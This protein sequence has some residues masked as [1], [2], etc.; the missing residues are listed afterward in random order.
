ME[1][2]QEVTI[3]A[4]PDPLLVS[5]QAVFP[6]IVQLADDNLLAIF[7]IGQAFDAAD[8]RAFCSK[9]KDLGR[10]WTAPER[11]HSHEFEPDQISETLKP[12]LLRDGSLLAT[13]Y[14]FVRPDDLAPIVDP[15][16]FE[17]LPLRNMVSKSTD[18]GQSWDV[19]RLVNIGGQPLEMS[20]PCIQLQS[21]RIL[22]AAPPFHLGAE[23]HSGW[24]VYS[25][26][27]GQNW[28]KLSTF[29]ESSSG[30]VAAWECRL[31]ETK[32][33]Q[34]VVLFWAYDNR[35]Q[36]NLNNH[37]VVSQDGG[38]TFGPAIDTGVRAQASNLMRLGD[39]KIL[40]IHSHR[41]DPVGLWVRQVDI[42]DNGFRVES[43]LNLFSGNAMGSDAT[44]IKKQFGSLK[45][46]Q[47]SLLHLSN[48]QVL[49]ACWAV[50]ECQHVIKGF[51]L[52]L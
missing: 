36:S 14:G 34:V 6:G 40:T 45:F 7:S 52:E 49:A 26:D 24:I 1:L 21:G 39:D 51:I 9:S 3:Y 10:T 33:G 11:L 23:G 38:E 16:T 44:N 19:P 8:H 37:M 25:D 30:A 20:G 17:V 27:G 4:N 48:G 46:G 12:L 29:F 50:E 32:A 42:A 35:E 5:R 31:C 47:P 22:A 43:E 41:E 18:D 13:G 15:E 28:G 2:V